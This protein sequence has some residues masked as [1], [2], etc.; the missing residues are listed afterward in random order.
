MRLGIIG[1]GLIGKK[2][3][4]AARGHQIH[5]AADLDRDLA[6]RLAEKVGAKY[7][8]AWQEVVQADLDAVIIAATHDM[9]A[10]MSQAALENG[11]HVLVE[12]PAARSALEL[13]P[14]VN[15]AAASGKIVKVGFNHRFHPAVR[16]ARKIVDSGCL[17]SLM[18]VIGRY[19]HGGRIGYEKEWRCVREISGGG[20]LVDQGSHLI[21][22]ARWFLGD[23]SLAY[24]ATPTYF[25]NIPVEDNCF[26]ALTSEEGQMAWL[27]ASWTE[28]KNTFSL[29]IYGTN[30]KLRLDGLGGSYGTERITL[31]QMLPEMGPPETTTWEYPFPDRSWSLE[32]E[33]FLEAIES[34]DQPLGNLSDA[35]SVLNIID[36]AYGRSKE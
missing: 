34:G 23:L 18:Y 22:L 10:E 17:G 5:I 26:L 30:G 13:G 29:Q 7:T 1:C 6:G 21:D 4:A 3:A 24:S 15:A 2:R 12:K 32:F 27:H 33:N 19:G 28:W 36:E 8:T 16:Q 25:W 35:M 11:K 14:V 20:E 31:Y 9:L